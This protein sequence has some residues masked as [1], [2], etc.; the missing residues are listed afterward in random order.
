MLDL[1]QNNFLYNSIQAIMN[2]NNIKEKTTVYNEEFK[3]NDYI[4]EIEDFNYNFNIEKET[5]E[6]TESRK[7]EINDDELSFILN[8]LNLENPKDKSKVQKQAIKAVNLDSSLPKNE[9]KDSVDVVIRE[10]NK[11]KDSS[12]SS[13]LEEIIDSTQIEKEKEEKSNCKKLSDYTKPYTK[14]ESILT[15]SSHQI[16][17]SNSFCNNM[18]PTQNYTMNMNNNMQ[19]MYG[20]YNMNNMGYYYSLPTNYFG[21]YGGYYNQGYDAIHFLWNEL[22]QIKVPSVLINRIENTE[23]NFFVSFCCNQLGREFIIK[24]VNEFFELYSKKNYKCQP[25]NDSNKFKKQKDDNYSLLCKTIISKIKHNFKYMIMPDTSCEV[26]IKVLKFVCFQDRLQLWMAIRN[27]NFISLAGNKNSSLLI[28][29]MLNTIKNKIEEVFIIKMLCSIDFQNNFQIRNDYLSQ[30]YS[31]ILKEKTQVVS[32]E[33]WLFNF[34]NSII[35]KEYEVLNN[36]TKTKLFYDNC[37]YLSTNN[38]YSVTVMQTILGR[39]AAFHI[40]H[41]EDFIYLNLV[42]LSNHPIG[43]MLISKFILVNKIEND[44]KKTSLIFIKENLHLFCFSESG[45]DVLISAIENWEVELIEEIIGCCIK[46]NIFSLQLNK[47]EEKDVE[48]EAIS[49]FSSKNYYSVNNFIN[50]LLLSRNDVSNLIFNFLIE[51]CDFYC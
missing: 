2:T 13:D 14:C 42:N 11:K 30:L 44:Y 6:L 36:L 18:Y 33:A 50:K 5:N 16:N 27:L 9:A 29:N 4:S 20:A 25:Q 40:T 49:L 12:S 21:Y 41:I 35:E 51:N 15:D 3:I 28:I 7:E 43:K 17:C 24:I 45:L 46:K 22:S 34:E 48:E 26:L 1:S 19:Y 31:T 38:F 23:S 37:F 39:F 10:L 8:K 47:K 32:G